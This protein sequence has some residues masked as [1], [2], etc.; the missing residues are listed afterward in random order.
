MARKTRRRR[1]E[2]EQELNRIKDSN[3]KVSTTAVAPTTV[4]VYKDESKN[5]FSNKTALISL[6]YYQHYNYCNNNS[7]NYKSGNI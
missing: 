4:T 2:L 6:N 1:E 5:L 3:D 7:N